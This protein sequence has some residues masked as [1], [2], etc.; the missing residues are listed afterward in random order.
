MQVKSDSDIPQLVSN[1]PFES[2]NTTSRHKRPRPE[3]SPGSDF[4]DLKHEILKMLTTW[5]NEQ[6]ERLK[7]FTDDQSSCLS[8]LG[9]EIAELKLQNLEIQKSNNEI[10][11][12]AMF[13]SK[14][15][16][17]MARQVAVLQKE[18]QAYRNNV[19]NLEMKVLDLQQL[20]R[21]SCVEIRN[22][23][24]TEKET[25]LDLTTV[26]TKIGATVNVTLNNSQLRD[27]YRLPGKPGTVR[28]II[29]EFTNVQIKNK[30]ITS[31]RD[32]NKAH[33]NEGRLNTQCIGLS[34]E[35]RPVYVAEYL[36]VS[37]R[38]LFYTAREFAKQ[39]QFKFCWTANGNIF[40]RK[41]EGAK[42]ILI[43]SE[44]TLRDLQ[45]DPDIVSE[46]SP[47]DQQLDTDARSE[48]PLRDLQMDTV[49]NQ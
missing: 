3:F 24:T 29:A 22:I 45:M 21:S 7:K 41:I 4:Q 12:S 49:M 48:Q 14:Q 10:T 35:R 46:P 5:K 31:A 37:S 19:N 38:K 39:K 33:P 11:K 13:I 23:P 17:D 16:D 8:K 30:L 36:P 44:Q 9:S 6:E 27:I 47:R 1:S 18:N 34:G 42:Q 32:F 43:R 15:Y 2:V 28:P 26:I 40:L 20:S 25:P